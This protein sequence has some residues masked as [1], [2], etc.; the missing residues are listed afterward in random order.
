MELSRRADWRAACRGSSHV[1][2]RVTN[3]PVGL[4]ELL[5]LHTEDIQTMEYYGAIRLPFIKI[6]LL[7]RQQLR[8]IKIDMC[9]FRTRLLQIDDIAQVLG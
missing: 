4:S 9:Y 6:I 2:S 5:G 3:G 7:H 1:A 8:D